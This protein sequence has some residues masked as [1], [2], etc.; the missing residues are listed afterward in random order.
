MLHGLE[1]LWYNSLVETFK[2]D[3][4]QCAAA[5]RARYFIESALIKSRAQLKWQPIN[6][7]IK[8]RDIKKL[9]APIRNPLSSPACKK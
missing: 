8:T 9:R 5:L 6:T 4:C 2:F 3:F 7:Q 1:P